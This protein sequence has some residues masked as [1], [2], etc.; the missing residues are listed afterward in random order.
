[1]RDTRRQ[2]TEATP[3]FR[4][5]ARSRRARAR[6]DS[7][8]RLRGAP[9]ITSRTCARELKR[10]GSA[11]PARSRE[12][13]RGVGLPCRVS[14]SV[15]RRRNHVVTAHT[16]PSAQR[17]LCRHDARLQAA[18]LRSISLMTNTGP[19][20]AL[21]LA[22]WRPGDP[23]CTG[24]R[25]CPAAAAT[26]Q[27]QAPETHE[28]ERKSSRAQRTASRMSPPATDRLV[29]KCDLLCMNLPSAHAPLPASAR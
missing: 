25:P 4:V 24:P 3:R 21:I 19:V 29:K 12:A 18:A 5:G 16:A 17:V 15:L 20:S 7:A 2:T 9:S 27:Q 6:C 10:S 13:G 14:T 23:L 28:S 26:C 11:Q 8:A 22:S 1:V